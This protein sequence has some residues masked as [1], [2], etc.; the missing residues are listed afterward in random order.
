MKKKIL[1]ILNTASYSGAENI[2]I[3]IINKMSAGYECAYVSLDGSI[4]NILANHKITFL[5]VAKITV[6]EIRRVAK[7]FNPHLI[8]AHD[9]RTSMICAVSGLQIPIISHLHNNSPW[10]RTYHPYSFLYLLATLKFA[11]ILA[12]S[13]SIFSEYVFGGQIVKKSIVVSNSINID[14]VLKKAKQVEDHELNY[15]VI[16]LGRLAIQKNPLRFIELVKRVIIDYPDLKAALIGDGPLRTQCQE[17]INSLNLAKNIAILGFKSNPYG[18]LAASKVLCITSDWEGY[19]L[20]ALEA[21]ALGIPV[22]ATPV[23]GLPDIID[24][25]CGLLTA[26]ED[27]YVAEVKKLLT[28]RMYWGNKSQKAI[29]KSQVLNN[30]ESYFENLSKIYRQIIL[31]LPI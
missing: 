21:L 5:P 30:T 7:L 1:H 4:R 2:A 19:G 12:V 22:V 31:E 18:I 24:A 14:E 29:A 3:S 6:S 10:I 28:D 25:E 17:R 11:K 20:V 8:H 13:N 15:D 26:D 16:F 23:G 27:Q 9:Y